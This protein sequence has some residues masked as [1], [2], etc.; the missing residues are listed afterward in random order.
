MIKLFKSRMPAVFIGHGSPMNIVLNNGF[1]RSLAKLGKS[2]PRPDAILVVSAHW[3]TENSRVLCDAENKMIY[4]F[5][6]F[7]EDL[8]KYEYPAKG[9]PDLAAKIISA[10]G[11]SSTICGKWGLDH[12]AWA[13][14]KWI[15]PQADIPVI[16]LSLDYSL[17]SLGHYNLAKKLSM[18]RDCGV[19]IIGSGNIVHNLSLMN[20]KMDSEPYGWAIEFDRI[21]ADWLEKGDHGKINDYSGLGEIADFSVP[22]DEHFLPMIYTIATQKQNEKVR[23][24]HESFQHSSISMRCFM[25]S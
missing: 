8:Y 12:G 22:T 7:P 25:I 4:D 14:L 18:L 2:L 1:T 15:Y 19:L 17:T 5:A 21:M 11:A 24:T 20:Y 3:M 13:I 16:Q 23:F 9:S 10:L 6:G